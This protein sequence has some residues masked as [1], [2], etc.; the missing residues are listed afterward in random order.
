MRQSNPNGAADTLNLENKKKA[1]MCMAPTTNF[2]CKWLQVLDD[3]GSSK[4]MVEVAVQPCQKPWV[5]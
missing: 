4:L 1:S 5:S 3:E 2:P